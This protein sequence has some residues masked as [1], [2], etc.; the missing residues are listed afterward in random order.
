MLPYRWLQKREG[1]DGDWSG[2]ARA[3]REEDEGGEKKKDGPKIGGVCCWSGT[4]VRFSLI[5]VNI[6]ILKNTLTPP[7]LPH[8]QSETIPEH[9]E[10]RSCGVCLKFQIVV[11]LVM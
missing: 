5:F 9:V 3:K 7:Q 1:A 10:C 8:P 11:M 4:A 2:R 6:Y